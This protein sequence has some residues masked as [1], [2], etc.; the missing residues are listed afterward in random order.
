ML[1]GAI[2]AFGTAGALVGFARAA[3]SV[4]G[5]ATGLGVKVTTAAKVIRF[6]ATAGAVGFTA[7]ATGVIAGGIGVT[8]GA[9]GAVIT[10][11]AFGAAT[12]PAGVF[13]NSGA[14]VFAIGFTLG[15]LGGGLFISG[16]AAGEN[17]VD[18]VYDDQEMNPVVV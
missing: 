5:V 11:G 3:A 17:G 13:G 10:A 6:I 7:G 2:G 1:P 8:A 15:A 12:I 14:N 9:V 4:I 18:E 16:A